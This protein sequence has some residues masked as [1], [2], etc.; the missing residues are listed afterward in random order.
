MAGHGAPFH[1]KMAG[2]L[3]RKGSPDDRHLEEM[4]NK[5]LH[6]R[7]IAA[8]DVSANEEKC[9]DD[10]WLVTIFLESPYLL[11][12]NALMR[13]INFSGTNVREVASLLR[14]IASGCP[15]LVKLNLAFM[16]TSQDCIGTELWPLWALDYQ[17]DVDVYG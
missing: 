1:L 13:E 8:I 3:P 6:S 9:D 2:T 7:R 17:G 14:G 12:R 15:L 4:V 16:V 5:K 11:R 10:H